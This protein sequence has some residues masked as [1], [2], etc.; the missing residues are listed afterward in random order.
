MLMEVVG[1]FALETE[2]VVDGVAGGGGHRSPR[3]QTEGDITARPVRK[4]CCVPWSWA[5]R[6]TLLPVSVSM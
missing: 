2:V 6:D 5:R 1:A 4:M 3:M